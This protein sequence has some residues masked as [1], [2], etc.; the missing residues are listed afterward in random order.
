MSG[1][2][3]RNK[4]RPGTPPTASIKLIGRN[5]EHQY[6]KCHDG[7]AAER[8]RTSDQRVPAVACHA[9]TAS[10]SVVMLSPLLYH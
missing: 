5:A 10:A 3:H 1:A 7:G 6:T 4:G 9:L 8:V 2:K